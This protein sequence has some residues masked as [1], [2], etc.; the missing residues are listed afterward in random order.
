MAFVEFQSSKHSNLRLNI[1]SFSLCYTRMKFTS[2]LEHLR[3]WTFHPRQQIWCICLIGQLLCFLQQSI[4][5]HFELGNKL[6]STL[7]YTW[8]N[9]EWQSTQRKWTILLNVPW[10]I[11]YNLW[12]MAFSFGPGSQFWDIS[13]EFSEKTC[14]EHLP[15]FVVNNSQS[16]DTRQKCQ[17]AAVCWEIQFQSIRC[18]VSYASHSVRS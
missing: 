1:L 12:N 6:S 7:C 10:K 13:Q 4:E 15:P 16:L 5:I 3:Q 17:T 14:R 11:Q 2:G 8:P 18:E 9:L